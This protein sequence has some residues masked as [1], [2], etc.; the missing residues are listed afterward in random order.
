MTIYMQ[1]VPMNNHQTTNTTIHAE[2]LVEPGI[3]DKY[4]VTDELNMRV[5]NIELL[6]LPKPVDNDPSD[7]NPVPFPVAAKVCE[8]S[9]ESS[10]IDFNLLN[11]SEPNL[12]FDMT[13]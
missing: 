11:D 2:L 8:T 9:Q 13:S 12:E 7:N 4:V 1:P 5:G 10:L 3:T 6:K